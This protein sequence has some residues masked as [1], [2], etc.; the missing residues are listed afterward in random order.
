MASAVSPPNT[1][2]KRLSRTVLPVDSRPLRTPGGIHSAA[3]EQGHSLWSVTDSL[4]VADR[5]SVA[6]QEPQ[7]CHIAAA[8]NIV[9]L[10][11]LA[12]LS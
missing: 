11:R 3:V 2:Y 10:D 1:P 7:L 9:R 12:G 4:L 6:W 5:P 8:T